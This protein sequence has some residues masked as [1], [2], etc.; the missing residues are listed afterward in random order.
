MIFFDLFFALGSHNIFVA[1]QIFQIYLEWLGNLVEKTLYCETIHFVSLI[2]EDLPIRGVRNNGQ[3]RLGKSLDL[4]HG[5]V[6]ALAD[7]RLFGGGLHPVPAA[8]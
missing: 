8:R 6:D 7:V 4:G 3:H 5:I 1:G 2:E